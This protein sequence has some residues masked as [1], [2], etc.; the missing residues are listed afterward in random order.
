MTVNVQAIRAEALFVSPVQS[1]DRPAPDDVLRAV[2]TTLRRFGMRG[3]AVR[4]AGEFGEHPEIAVTRMEW[5]LTMITTAYPTPAKPAELRRS[6]PQPQ[7]L[8]LAG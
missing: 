4:V 3:C 8:A 2:A 5:A 6:Q 7:Q 1:S